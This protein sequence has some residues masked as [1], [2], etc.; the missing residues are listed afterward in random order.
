MGLTHPR[1]GRKLTKS[2]I[3]RVLHNPIYAGEFRWKGKLYAG[4]HTPIISRRLFEDVQDVFEVLNRPRYKKHKHAFTGLMT[5][6]LC[7]CAMTAEVKKGTYIY[8][9]CTG[10]KGRCGNTWIREG[11]LSGLFADV[12]KQ[13]HISAEVAEWITE[14]LRESQDDKQKFHRASVMRLQQQYLA[15]QAKIDR[16][17]EDR[18]SGRVSDDL[19]ER[20]AQQWEQ[21]LADI[22]RDTALHE[23]A[24]HDYAAKGSKIL[25]LAQTAPA[26]FVSQNSDEQAR[27]LKM[28]LSNCSFDRG[29]LS[30]S[31]VKPFDLLARGNENGD[32]PGIRDSNPR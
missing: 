15:V 7:G 27:L 10:F 19:W 4:L 3:H 25:E 16:A 14:A 18:L 8:Y 26:Q 31:W 21:E 28:L 2:E 9:H 12:V 29:S 13:I 20:K 1:S 22:R 24:S 11:N 5:C 6:G 30:V 23:S 32:W 17:Y